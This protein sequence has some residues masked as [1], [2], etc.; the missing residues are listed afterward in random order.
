MV[1]ND[2]F[3]AE[4]TSDDKA[5]RGSVRRGRGV[6]LVAAGL[7]AGGAL[8][9]GATAFA[10]SSSSSTP[11]DS[12]GTPSAPAS[13][14]SGAAPGKAGGPAAVR[15]DEKELTG[16]AA[17][18]ARAAALKAVPGG[19]VYRVETDAGDAAYEAHMKKADGTLVTVKLDKNFVVTKVESGMGLGDPRPAGGRG[20]G[21]NDGDGPGG[22]P[23]PGSTG[24][25]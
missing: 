17:S 20:H 19:T 22:T 21:D 25:A 2:D 12:P 9:A 11:S 23:P 15:S 5:S 16:T 3:A 18:K 1:D 14:P 4:L 6:A 24:H 13:Q 10:T 8:A 7:V